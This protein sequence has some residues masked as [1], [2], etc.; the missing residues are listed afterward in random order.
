M[1]VK[2]ERHDVAGVHQLL[3]GR[4]GHLPDHRHRRRYLRRRRPRQHDSRRTAAT[5]TRAS[6]SSGGSNGAWQS[7]NITH[8]LRDRGVAVADRPP[9]ISTT[10]T[11]PSAARSSETALWF[12]RSYRRLV[13]NTTPGGSLRRRPAGHRRPVDRQ[14]LG[15]GHLAGGA[16]RTG[17]PP[18]RI[19]PGRARARLHR[20]GAGRGVAG[21][22]RPGDGGQQAR[23]QGLLHRLRQVD[24]DA[25]QQAAARK[26]RSLPRSTTTR[27]SI[28]PASPLPPVRPNFY[29]SFPRI[30]ILRGTLTGASDFTPTFRSRWPTT[31]SSAVTYA[32][33]SHNLKVGAP[34]A[35][36]PGR[37]AGRLDQ[38]RPERAVPQRRGGQRDGPE[39]AGR[40]RSITSTPTSASSSRTRGRSAV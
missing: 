5:A 3:D 13:L 20:S 31:L 24:V 38:R 23:S 26:R 6:S 39:C 15:P 2:T 27:S 36:R 22:D 19:V 17:S 25:E 18:T 10:S 32:S 8:E 35:L 37:I 12:F 1:P 30:D 11:P 14:R 34:V 28:S 29:T 40:R 4:R 21:A 16:R 7:S 33:G 9:T